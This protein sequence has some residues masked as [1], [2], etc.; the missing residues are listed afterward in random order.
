MAAQSARPTTK[1]RVHVDVGKPT[2]VAGRCNNWGVTPEQLKAA[3]AAVGTSA[4]A[5]AKA[6][7]RPY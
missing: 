5:V 7:G 3:L 4:A 2:E 1:E 6:L